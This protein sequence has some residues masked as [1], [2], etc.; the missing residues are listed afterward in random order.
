MIRLLEVCPSTHSFPRDVV[1]RLLYFR[2]SE[3]PIFEALS[4]CWGT[5]EKEYFIYCD[6]LRYWVTESLLKFLL[7]YRDSRESQLLWV[8]QICINQDDSVEKSLQLRLMGDIYRQAEQVIIWLGDFPGTWIGT[9]EQALI[10]DLARLRHTPLHG[11]LVALLR[12]LEILKL[13]KRLSKIRYESTAQLGSLETIGTIMTSPWFTRTWIVQEINAARRATA[14]IGNIRVGWSTFSDAITFVVNTGMRFALANKNLGPAMRLVS[15]C[16]TLAADRNLPMLR[17]LL[18]ARHLKASLAQD[19]VLGL[20]HLSTDFERLG[21]D[22]NCSLDPKQ[23]YRNVVEALLRKDNT[24][25]FLSVPRPRYSTSTAGLPSWVP[26]WNTGS[27]IVIPLAFDIPGFAPNYQASKR[28]RA[29][30]HPGVDDWVLTIEGMQFDTL[31]TLSRVYPSEPHANYIEDVVVASERTADDMLA[32]LDTLLEWAKMT[33]SVAKLEP[34]NESRAAL[35]LRTI[36][37]GQLSAD[38]DACHRTFRY[39][40]GRYRL[41]LKLLSLL[42]TKTSII[43][44]ACRAIE[45]SSR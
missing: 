31:S 7:R 44:R 27:N 9:P 15:I 4:Y 11:E 21:I 38:I 40:V 18:Y 22:L 24:L 10:K 26:D 23:V 39:L 5:S 3:N 13:F 16:L 2:L 8:D 14:Y 29:S 17:C 45:R 20:C 43:G 25:E 12:Q 42:E 36:T 33:K 32:E 35:L 37:A 19:K 1:C 30:L 28:P 34:R 41:R 6:G